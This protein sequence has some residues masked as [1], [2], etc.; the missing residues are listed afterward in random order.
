M[1]MRAVPDDFDNVQ[2]LHSPYGAVHN[3]GPPIPSPMD[4][5][6]GYTDHMSPPPGLNPAF[7]HVG[8]S[9]G[10][11]NP[12][13]LSPMSIN[14]SDRYYSSPMSNGP[15]SSNPFDRQGSY[16]P[17]SRQQVRPLQP[18][19][20]RE[21]MSRSRT[22][23]LNS[24]LRTSMSWKGESLDYNNYPTGHPSPA[25]SGLQQPAYQSEQMGNSGVHAQQ[26]YDANS[27]P[28]PS[29]NSSGKF[30]LLCRCRTYVLTL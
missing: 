24:P 23:A 29:R 1:K 17:H 20:L 7:G 22:D 4:F 13:A 25:L 16:Q 2:A 8:F 26:Q 18:L 21:T 12:E 11:G 10:I 5:T 6:P 9:G 27:Y 14:A 15:R 28:S 30:Q 3:V 19:Q